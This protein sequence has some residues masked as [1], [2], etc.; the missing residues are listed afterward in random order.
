M[1]SLISLQIDDEIE[2]FDSDITE[3]PDGTY[4]V[5]AKDGHTV[6]LSA[7]KGGDP[8]VWEAEGTGTI[9]YDIPPFS[10]DF[11]DGTGSNLAMPTH[12]YADVTA[13]TWVDVSL[14]TCDSS[15]HIRNT[16][17]Y[18]Q[19]LLTLDTDENMPEVMQ[20][21]FLQQSIILTYYTYNYYHE[22]GKY[23]ICINKTPND[24]CNF[25]LT[26]V[27]SEDSMDKIGTL[28]FRII[29][30]GG[31]GG[32]DLDV[33]ADQIAQIIEGN[34][35][36]LYAGRELMF[37]G[38]IRRVTNAFQPGSNT[39]TTVGVWDVECDNHL[40]TM[41]SHRVNAWAM[42]ESGQYVS[43]SPG[44]IL[45]RI[46]TPADNETTY[47]DMC[48][49]FRGIIQCVGANVAYKLNSTGAT[50]TESAGSQYQH[51]INLHE[52]TNYDLRVRPIYCVHRYH[53]IVGVG[54]GVS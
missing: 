5:V 52:L 18:G 7:T 23:Y 12:T 6:Q 36:D 51:I 24:T 42:P 4:F 30:V 3:I 9:A 2:I 13:K 44:N 19:Y 1:T 26:N 8:I 54:G 45:R 31:E 10:W 27:I 48:G 21:G 14:Q 33:L 50:D 11:G 34:F 43:D 22:A 35:I 16:S 47:P 41:R 17:E 15:G 25:Y 46:M 20:P 32:F 37:S 38:K 39:A 49:D 29:S 53:K 28:K 40:A